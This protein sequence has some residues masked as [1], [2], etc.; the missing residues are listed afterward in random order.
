MIADETDIETL[1][2]A[3][4]QVEE[5]RLTEAN[6]KKRFGPAALIGTAFLSS[7]LGAGVMLGANTFLANPA[8]DLAPTQAKLTSLTDETQSL[9]AEAKT[10]K[11][12]IARLQRDIKTKPAA[13][14]AVDL[15]PLETRLS[16]LENRQANTSA[17]PID[18]EMLARLEALQSEGSEAL[19]LTDILA[20]LATLENRPV[21]NN[22]DE[23][24][25]ILA[26]LDALET[27]ASSLTKARALTILPPCSALRPIL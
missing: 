17:A 26:R 21:D 6:P 4:F 2:D 13:M 14:P 11:A 25:D 9:K 15:K 22:P 16:T 10:L 19:D 27:K 18:E 23:I 1:P 20:R 7:L 12:Q 5:E 8:P 24:A 3:A